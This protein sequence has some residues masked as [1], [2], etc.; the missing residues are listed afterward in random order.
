MDI[1]DDPHVTDSGK[2]LYQQIRR[3]GREEGWINDQGEL[4]VAAAKLG[5]GLGLNVN[6]V[7]NA[8]VSL[9][10]SGWLVDLGRESI[11]SPTRYV[12]VRDRESCAA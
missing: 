7:T 12:I 10:D 6:K 5:Y 4:Q 2:V 3:R 11:T 1:L 8:I 9:V